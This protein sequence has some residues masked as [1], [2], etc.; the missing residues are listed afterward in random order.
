M[1]KLA[2]C[3]AAFACAFSTPA[4]AN[5]DTAQSILGTWKRVESNRYTFQPARSVRLLEAAPAG[6]LTDDLTKDANAFL[7]DGLALILVHNGTIVF[8]G[9][10][11]GAERDSKLRAYSMTKSLTSL[12]IGEA[13]CAGKL[14]S[15]DE[16]ASSFATI[17]GDTAYGKSS[18]RNLLKMASGAQSPAGYYTGI[19]DMDE[20]MKVANQQMP[21]SALFARYGALEEEKDGMRFVYNGL[22]AEALGHVVAASTGQPLHQW[23]EQTVWQKAGGETAFGWYKD[24]AGQGF[25]EL[26]VYGTAR[27]FTRIGLYVLDRLNGKPGEACVSQY[28]REAVRSQITKDW[29]RFPGYGFG[30]HTDDTGN[31]WFRGHGGQNI[32]M[33]AK[34]GTLLVTHGFS[35]GRGYFDY[36]LSLWSAFNEWAAKR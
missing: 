36:L 6:T 22:N 17:L 16:R 9:Y 34:N 20:F 27:D 12:A 11:N 35:I 18:L 13:L 4:L 14:K 10:A 30:I 7:S 33:N 1:N 26:G 2:L 23:F 3:V 24:S 32:G 21:M 25:A 15:L 5:H 19:H 8:E 28:L 29:P 31:P